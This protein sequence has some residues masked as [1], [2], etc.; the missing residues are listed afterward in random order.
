MRKIVIQKEN[1][2]VVKLLDGKKTYIGRAKVHPEDEAISSA[3]TGA[4]I[5]E[6][7]AKI[8]RH[9]SIAKQRAKEIS[10]L[11]KQ[12]EILKASK[13]YHEKEAP[14]REAFLTEYLAKKEAFF[15]KLQRIRQNPTRIFET[16]NSLAKALEEW[17][18][19]A[20]EGKIDI[21]GM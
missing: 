12:I 19:K 17:K 2:T 1:E 8:K 9:K 4:A 3:R 14:L 11:E 13:E 21:D 10:D 20:E 7:R 16:A 18:V 6:T 5:A 15:H